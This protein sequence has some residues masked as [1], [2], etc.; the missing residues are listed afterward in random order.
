DP[1][2]YA[3][4]TDWQ[5]GEPVGTARVWLSERIDWLA[6]RH[7]GQAGNTTPSAEVDDA[8]DEGVVFETDYA[9]PR[10]VIAWV[11]GLGPRAQ[12]LGPP[13]L[14]QEMEERLASIVE[15]HSE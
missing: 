13:E 3:Q 14:V 9:D 15:R 5:L 11:L 2:D 8:P 1:R 7:F 10:Q 12:I 6:L 4:R